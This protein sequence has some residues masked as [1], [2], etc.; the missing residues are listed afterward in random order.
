PLEVLWPLLGSAHSNICKLAFE[1]IQQAYPAA[2]E[3]LEP[4][5]RSML[6]GE[7]VQGAFAPRAPYRS[8]E[9]VALMG[10]AT[11]E[12][13]AMVVDLLDFPFWEV[14]VR[15]AQTLGALRRNIPDRAI[16]RLIELRKDPESI[17]VQTAAE[18]ALA[19]ILSLEQG[20][21]EE[22]GV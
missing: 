15:A 8:A 21:E 11:P 22:L 18:L 7:A 1:H 6:R 10:R 5:L 3:E 19:E 17:D 4:A 16:Q 13:V 14:R 2:L 12:V 20:M 9:M